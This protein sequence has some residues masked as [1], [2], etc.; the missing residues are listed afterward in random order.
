MTPSFKFQILSPAGKAFEGVAQYVRAPG[1]MGNFGIMARH[2]PLIAA[3]EPGL[4]CVRDATGEHF[5]YTGE[6]IVDVSRSEVVMLVDE[7]KAV[8]NPVEAKQCLA[9]RRQRLGM[10]QNR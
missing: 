2:A 9:E 3:V 7:A 1:A 10:G 8:A 6:G 5:F 4:C